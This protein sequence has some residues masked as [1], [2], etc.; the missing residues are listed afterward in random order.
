[1]MRRLLV[2]FCGVM[3]AVAASVVGVSAQAS[4]AP[5]CPSVEV[6]FARGT[7]EAAPPVGATG[8]AF[9]DAVRTVLP[10][11][12]VRTYGVPY[13]A[14]ANFNNRLKFA[15]SVLQGVTLTQNRIRYLA[16]VCP[17]TRIILGG[18]SQGAVVASYAAT[19]GI[20]VPQRYANYAQY[21]PKPLPADVAS[22]I[23]SIVLFA[24]PSSRF[25]RDVGAPPLT[26]A[27][28]LAARTTKY[29]IPGDTI[30]NG[31]P[32]GQP[33]VL[34]VLYS[35]NGMAFDGARFSARHL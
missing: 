35:V 10:G 7:V 3:A 11:K 15:Q 28:S 24:P 26:I 21:A 27:P 12:S 20:A 29:C 32:V 30:C 17:R 4:A 18:Y 1:M 2:L 6:V 23:A 9:S 13:Q 5:G 34:H 31:A 25:I 22:H 8:L 19:G 16:R 14:S 33:N